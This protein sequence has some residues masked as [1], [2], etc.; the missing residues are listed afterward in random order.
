MLSLS[1]ILQAT[2]GYVRKIYPDFGTFQAT[3]TMVITWHKFLKFGG[4]AGDVG[5]LS[6]CFSCL[7]LIV[8]SS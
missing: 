4:N 8:L 1:L 5:S 6:I 3:W 2:A 7:S